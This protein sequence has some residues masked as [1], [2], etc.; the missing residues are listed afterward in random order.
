MLFPSRLYTGIKLQRYGD[1]F[2]YTVVDFTT[3][4][5]DFTTSAAFSGAEPERQGT[6][7]H[8]LELFRSQGEQIPVKNNRGPK[9]EPAVQMRLL[10][11]FVHI[12][13]VAVHLLSEGSHAYPLPAKFV[14]YYFPEMDVSHL[15][16]FV[17]TNVLT[18]D[19]KKRGIHCCPFHI[20]RLLHAHKNR[21]DNV[22]AHADAYNSLSS[23][24]TELRIF[25]TG[26]LHIPRTS[27]A[28]MSKIF[29]CSCKIP[30]CLEH[31]VM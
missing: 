27:T 28:A 9:N 3:F 29:I 30:I 7:A 4:V 24:D 19:T 18:H 12:A 8:K 11:Q 10:E 15:S 5:D 20:S 14:A 13:A 31:S 22:R 26:A 23:S 17:Y 16:C 2:Y 1:S 6:S 25:H 21:T